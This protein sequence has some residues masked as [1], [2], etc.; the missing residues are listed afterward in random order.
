MRSQHTNT[1]VACCCSVPG[2]GML[3]QSAGLLGGVIGDVA[4]RAMA[5]L[6]PAD[7]IVKDFSL[8]YPVSNTATAS[9]V[10]GQLHVG[11]IRT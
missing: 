2:I 11:G 10:M 6:P 7:V 9:A 3:L 8:S 5:L 4:M 1:H